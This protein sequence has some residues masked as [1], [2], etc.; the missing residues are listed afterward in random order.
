MA[1]KVLI[2]CLAAI[3]CVLSVI[4]A[5]AYE[6]PADSVNVIREGNVYT[7][8]VS[9]EELKNSSV[10]VVAVA[11]GYEV[12]DDMQASE[13]AYYD[14][15]T[16]N[17]EGEASLK[18]VPREGFDN[19][20]GLYVS[21]M[22]ERNID[23]LIGK[24]VYTAEIVSEH[25]TVSASKNVI[26]EGDTVTFKIKP[27][28]GY[29]VKSV[30]VNGEAAELMDTSFNVEYITGNLS[31]NVEYEIVAPSAGDVVTFNE[32]IFKDKFEGVFKDQYTEEAKNADYAAVVFSKVSA[33]SYEYGIIYSKTNENPTADGA[34][35]KMLKAEK[36]GTTGNYGMYLFAD[37][38]G[39]Y[40]V[41]S[42]VKDGENIVL[43]ENVGTLEIRPAW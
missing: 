11:N 6:V 23:E 27:S 29:A 26:R 1:R 28:Y 24:A 9:A 37:K 20:K 35:C 41:R 21:L 30:T 39:S 36:V 17:E 15:L 22:S 13:V 40:F 33:L 14:E 2:T 43:S 34:D 7:V 19:S 12:P 25:G 10:A 42:Y 18:F 4:S 32:L 31:I 5:G 8:S 3:L 16:V 38:P